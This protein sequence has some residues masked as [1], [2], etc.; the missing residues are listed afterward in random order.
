MEE[1]DCKGVLGRFG[2]GGSILYLDCNGDYTDLCISLSKI[3]D[4]YN[5]NEYILLHANSISTKLT[6][7]ETILVFLKKEKNLVSE[8][9]LDLNTQGDTLQHCKGASYDIPRP[10]L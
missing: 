5:L 9:K 2:D 3:I 10:E 4:V 8:S 6:K 1:T 7:S